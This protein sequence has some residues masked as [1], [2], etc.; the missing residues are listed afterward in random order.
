MKDLSWQFFRYLVVGV[1]G[2]LIYAAVFA[3][4][5]ETLL[6]ADSALSEFT[7]GRN[8][9][10]SNS[11]AFLISSIFVYLKNRNWV[12]EGGKHSRQS[13]ILLFYGVALVAYLIGTPAGTWL[14]TKYEWN[15]YFAL[16]VT[17]G[18]SVLVN[19]AGRKLLV[20]KT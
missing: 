7:R 20:F 14:V 9:L 18:A 3:L 12:F 15:E 16:L 6:S 1:A 4:L 17:V 2:T 19:F 5:N 11:A 10:L 13:E 8:F